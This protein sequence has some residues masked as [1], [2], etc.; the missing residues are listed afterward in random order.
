MAQLYLL[1]FGPAQFPNDQAVCLGSQLQALLSVISLDVPNPLWFAS[2]VEV[3]QSPTLEVTGKESTP[4]YIG[5][6]EEIIR[7]AG[8]VDQFLSGIFLAVE[9]SA[10]RELQALQ[11]YTD[12]PQFREIEPAEIEIR[13]FDTSFFEVY[14]NRADYLTSLATKYQMPILSGEVV[15]RPG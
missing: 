13:A 6:T 11:F 2:D 4:T 15:D 10:H 3:N 1:Q 12:D 8:S 14:A 9:E 5:H 7:F